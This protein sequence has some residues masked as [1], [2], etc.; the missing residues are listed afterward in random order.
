MLNIGLEHFLVVSGILFC[1]GLMCVIARH[2]VVGILIGIELML[3]AA[4]LNF[5]AFARYGGSNLDGQV[6]ALFV[7]LLAA[8]EVAVGLA[9][10]INLFRSVGSADPDRARNLSG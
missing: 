5:V 6:F 10:M 8:C 9:I 4:N 2:N 1:L 7:I 3:N